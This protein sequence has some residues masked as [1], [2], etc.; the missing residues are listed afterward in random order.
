MKNAS[1]LSDLNLNTIRRDFDV[2][3]SSNQGCG[4]GSRRDRF[5]PKQCNAIRSEKFLLRCRL[6]DIFGR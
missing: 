5:F 6:A 1:N 2:K 4:K 3:Y